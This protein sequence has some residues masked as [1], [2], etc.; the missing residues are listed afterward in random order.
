MVNPN[1][2]TRKYLQE[3]RILIGR[4][5]AF[6]YSDNVKMMNYANQLPFLSAAPDSPNLSTTPNKL[7]ISYEEWRYSLSLPGS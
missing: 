6:I 3:T 4:I 7:S 1:F 5:A 2:F